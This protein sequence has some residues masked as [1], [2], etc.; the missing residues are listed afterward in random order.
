MLIR[1]SD[2]QRLLV[3]AA[4]TAES[5][6]DNVHMF[7][8]GN[9]YSHYIYLVD[10]TKLP[11]VEN[12]LMGGISI[13]EYGGPWGVGSVSAHKGYGPLLYRLAMGWVAENG[14]G[15]GLTKNRGGETSD[16][17]KRVWSK[18][19]SV[20]REP[21]SKIKTVGDEPMSPEY[22]SQADELKRMRAKPVKLTSEQADVAWNM[23]TSLE[24]G[25]QKKYDD[26]D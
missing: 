5:L 1:I 20:R 11:D 9:K 3:E 17:A 4:M 8:T 26:E 10:I 13:S 2:L 12:A 23:L 16:A 21:G 14:D 6:P 24:I 19:D 15:R 7:E 25:G 22:V 18:F